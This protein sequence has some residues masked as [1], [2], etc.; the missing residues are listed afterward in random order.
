[1]FHEPFGSRRC[2]AYSYASSPIKP[3]RLQGCR[4]VNEISPR[5]NL[6]AGFVEHTP[7]AALETAHKNNHVMAGGKG[8][9]VRQAVGHL[10]ANGVEISERGRR[11]YMDR[12]VVHNLPKALKRLGR[13]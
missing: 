1:M 6:P 7:V 13:L 12:N 2:T 10:P 11:L 5:V 8:T 4:R 9:Y 3:F